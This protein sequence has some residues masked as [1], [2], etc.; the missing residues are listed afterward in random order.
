MEQLFLGG[1][2]GLALGHHL[3]YQNITRA[4]S[5]PLTDHTMFI[6][7]PQSFFAHIRNII[8]KFF[9]AKPS[10]TN[11]RR[12]LVNVNTCETIVLHKSLTDNNCV[13]KVKTVKGN[14]PDQ[15]VFT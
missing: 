12:K 7:V 3:A 15:H 2:L 9:F 10:L 4:Y 14:K 13:L 1:Q 6:K 5:C 11:L 8:R